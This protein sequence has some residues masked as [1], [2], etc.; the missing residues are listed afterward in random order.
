MTENKLKIGISVGDIN[1]IGLEVILKTLADKRIL[2][3]CTPILYGST[4]VAS[5]HKNIIKV[6]DLSLHN[7]ADINS[8]NPKAVNVINC[9]LENV[10]ITLGKC[11]AE[12]GK[13]ASFSLEQATEDLRAG[14]ID[15]LITAPINKKA[16]QLSGFQ[17]PGHTEYLTDK[18]GA[19]ESLMLMV[20]EELRVGLVTNHIPI[21]QIATTITT[22]L[23]LRKIKLMDETLKMD[24]GINKPAIAIL[25]LNP[26]AGD[27]G[28]MGNEEAEVIFP[29]IEA[30]KAEGILAIGPY[31]A[32]GFFGSGNYANF[33]GIL[34]MYHD[35]GLAPFKALSFGNGINFTAGL[36]IIR[37]SPD[38][39]T[40]FDIA[41]KNAA[42]PASFRQALYLAIDSAKQR[43]EYIKMTENPLKIISL[44]N[45]EKKEAKNKKKD[46]KPQKNSNSKEEETT[47]AVK[48]E[49]EVEVEKSSNEKKEEKKSLT[50]EER[51]ALAA[52]KKKVDNTP[53]EKV[54]I[55]EEATITEEEIIVTEELTA[56]AED[57]V[58]TEDTIATEEEII[59]TEELT[60]TVEDVVIT[61]DTI[62]TEE[63]VI[64]TEELTATV[65]DVVITEDTIATEE[66]IIV[67]EE[68]TATAEDVVI[69]EDTIATEEEVIVTEE[70]T[71]TVEDVVITEGTAEEEAVSLENDII[72][73]MQP[74]T[75]LV[76][77]EDGSDKN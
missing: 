9:W 29:A 61:E 40:G 70:L 55:T 69:T 2:E 38:H 54:F 52:E 73:T 57:V 48:V 13:Y 49:V 77:N 24:F 63:E 44:N 32:D 28:V 25:G 42:D 6:K 56:T 58:I 41:G 46:S 65:E 43:A 39:G 23:I 20:H 7:A 5:Y 4:K 45:Y 15:A 18:F 19:E 1:G 35:Q 31:A 62:T 21:S 17:Y 72:Q 26:H 22:E 76:D 75:S 47:T 36:P 60:A 51:L 59:V 68:L 3:W 37:T 53:V 64:V 12:G 10:K 34:A 33:D 30:A 50:V 67:T 11:T 74:I 14:H 66:E 71:A 27:Q 8:I 16:M